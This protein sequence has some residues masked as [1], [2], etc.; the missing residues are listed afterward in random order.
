MMAFSGGVSRIKGLVVV[1]VMVGVK[2]GA[3]LV[4]QMRWCSYLLVVTLGQL[5][6]SR[7]RCT[8]LERRR[9]MFSDE[10]Y[11]VGNIYL[12]HC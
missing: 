5:P 3:E 9:W 1:V 2:I 11:F 10:Q 6:L 12:D 4:V 7:Y 8:Q